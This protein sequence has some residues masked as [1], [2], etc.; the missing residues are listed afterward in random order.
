MKILVRASVAGIIA[1]LIGEIT[2][3]LIHAMSGH[4]TTWLLPA[5]LFCALSWYLIRL[6]PTPSVQS[7]TATNQRL[8]LLPTFVD[9]LTQLLFVGLGGS[10]GREQAPRQMAAALIRRPE[11]LLIAGA[12][13]GALAAVYQVPIAG[14]L[15]S[16]ALLPRSLRTVKHYLWCAYISTV[17]LI[18]VI[19]LRGPHTVYTISPIRGDWRI[20]AMLPIVVLVAA[21]LGMCFR[22]LLEKLPRARAESVLVAIPVMALA[23]WV[24]ASYHPQV[25]GNGQLLVEQALVSMTWPDAISLIGEKLVLTIGLL[26]AGA[27]GGVLTPALAIGAAVGAGLADLAQVPATSLALVGA[28]STLAMTQRHWLFAAIFTLE[29]SRPDWWMW[30]VVVAAAAGA[31]TVDALRR[32]PQS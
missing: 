32:P 21:G 13:G 22:S 2:T 11:P 18:V 29:L 31:A 10:L 23:T 7:A 16:I 1:G 19:L 12:A 6:R 9:A 3:I 24:I 26:L 15:Y 4:S 5:S 28:A 8:A 14:T 25:T 27:A 20:L 17:A 30:G